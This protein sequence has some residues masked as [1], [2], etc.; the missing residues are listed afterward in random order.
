M[1]NWKNDC[2]AFVLLV[3]SAVLLFPSNDVFAQV[4][5]ESTNGYEVVIDDEAELLT[6]DEEARLLQSMK[7]ITEY[8]NVAFKSVDAGTEIIVDKFADL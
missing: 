3:V 5:Y 4:L 7:P 2:I 6:D 1:R 8:G